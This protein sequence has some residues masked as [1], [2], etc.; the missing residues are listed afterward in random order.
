MYFILAAF[1]AL[2]SW[3]D[4]PQSRSLFFQSAAEIEMNGRVDCESSAL[5]EKLRSSTSLCGQSVQDWKSFA[6]DL[7]NIPHQGWMSELA[8]VVYRNTLIT[9]AYAQLY[10]YSR[11]RVPACR[12]S[13][14]PWVGGASLGSLKSGQVMRSGLSSAVGGIE[15]FDRVKDANYLRRFQDVVGPFLVEDAIQS[16]TLT[17]G[18]GNRAIFEDL[19]WQLLAGASCGATTVIDTIEREKNWQK[20]AKLKASMK[21]WRLLADGSGSCEPKAITAANTNF[22]YVEQ[23]LVAQKAMYEGFFRYFA[24]WM[25][26]PLIEPALPQAMGHFPNFLDHARQT[27]HEWDI[28]FA[29]V[30]Q[31]V[32]WMQDQLKVMESAFQEHDDLLKPLYCAVAEDSR[33]ARVIVS[34]YSKPQKR[35]TILADGRTES[36]R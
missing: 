30:K 33:Q 19:Y 24:G 13:V 12:D 4:K 34:R 22:V 5:A 32:P 21:S 36:P 20:D 26:S 16:A 2:N 23:Y 27:T 35:K 6:K 18:E 17:L 11:A 28:N 10:L 9:E 15:E 14:L 1:F 7:I 8:A 29:D 3:A 31:R 25:L